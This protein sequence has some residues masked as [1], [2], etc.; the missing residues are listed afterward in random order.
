[1][2]EDES[3]AS[4]AERSGIEE[5]NEGGPLPSTDLADPE[6]AANSQLSIRNI[7]YWTI[8]DPGHTF[9]YYVG[10]IGN[11]HD[12]SMYVYVGNTTVPEWLLENVWTPSWEWKTS[13]LTNTSRTGTVRLFHMLRYNNQDSDWHDFNCVISPRPIIDTQL[14]YTNA[15]TGSGGDSTSV[16]VWVHEGSQISPEVTPTNSRWSLPLYSSVHPGTYLITVMQHV[17]GY[18]QRYALGKTITYLTYPKILVPRNG[19][20]IRLSAELKVS[21]DFGAP[22]RKI[23][24]ANASKDRE[25]G[26]GDADDSGRWEI[27][28][29]AASHFSVGGSITLN[30]RHIESIDAAWTTLSID[31][32]APP[33]IDTT[34]LEVEMNARIEGTG[35]TGFSGHHV[36]LYFQG[37]TERITGNWV[38]EGR[39]SIDV[40]LLP[41]KHTLTAEQVHKGVTSL[42]APLRV[43]HVRPA[44]P[45]PLQSRREGDFIFLHGTG[46][47]GPNVKIHINLYYIDANYLSASVTNGK[48]DIAI[49][50]TLAPKTYA[51]SCRQSVDGGENTRIYS[52]GWTSLVEINVPTPKPTVDTPAV[53][54]QGVTFS[55]LGR[56]WVNAKVQ[57]V[58]FE[59]DGTTEGNVIVKIDVPSTLAW[60][61][62]VSLAPGTYSN[63]KARQWVNSQFSDPA[64]IPQVIVPSQVPGLE[65]PGIG[66]IV[67]QTPQLKGITYKGSVVTFSIPGVEP[68]TAT[69]S[70]EG[71][72][73]ITAKELPPGIHTM[74]VTAEFGGQTSPALTRTFTVKTPVPEIITSDGDKLDPVPI[75]KGRG[76]KGGWL[77]IRSAEN[78][79]DLGK[80]PVG[81]G[82]DWSVQLAAQP[83]GE[84]KIYAL[85]FEKENSP[86]VSDPTEVVTVD[87]QLKPPTILQ[88]APNGKAE[89]VSEFSGEA[90]FRSTVELYIK[91]QLQPFVKDI[92]VG[93]NNT[94]NHIVTLPA[95]H[96]DLEVAVRYDGTLSA[97]ADH[98]VSVVPAVPKND[99]PLRAEK[100][101]TP[102]TMSGFGDKEG[103]E[104]VIESRDSADILGSTTV[105]D[106]KTWS[107]TV[108]QTMATDLRVAV[109]ARAGAG[110]DSAYTGTVQFTMLTPGPKIVEPQPGDWTGVRP[111]YS[112]LAEPGATIT[113]ALWFNS[114]T[115]LAEPTVAD[116]NGRWSVWGNQDLVEGAVWVVMRQTLDGRLSEWVESGRFMV[117][118]MP[119]GFEAPTVTFPLHG[120]EV[121][122]WPMFKGTGV[123]GSEVTIFKKGDS[124]TA[125]GS[126]KV[127]RNGEWEVRSQIELPVADNYECSV[128]QTRDG[129]T[130]AWLIPDRKFDVIQVPDGFGAAIIQAP[131]NDSSESHEQQPEFSGTGLAGAEVVIR[132]YNKTD[133]LAKTLVD[134]QGKWRVR[135]EVV[136]TVGPHEIVADQYR[137]GQC[138]TLSNTVTF[139]VAEKLYVPIIV[140]PNDN[141]HIT[142][143]G[144]IEGRALPGTVVR[145]V[146]ASHVSVA[147]GTG[148]TDAQ[149]RW[150]IV[151]KGL[152]VRK[153]SLIGDGKKNELKAH[154]ILARVFRVIDVG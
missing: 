121:G 147:Y 28:F 86:N 101:G 4:E 73:D 138:S 35:H 131:Q 37:A 105:L 45:G 107:T 106:D 103:D 118:R 41:G 82:G 61:K 87:I 29:D 6:V 34:P 84:L 19:D 102:F 69:A 42:R 153:I 44:M 50:A 65:K 146:D 85:M 78:H 1:M 88:P 97:K 43:V 33:I 54:T 142:P 152:P 114:D 3:K 112:G 27:K 74:T 79:G 144:V 100:V 96:T 52:N 60:T 72:F 94:W 130:S 99:T 119:A 10:V 116:E 133:V 47:V 135:S 139:T 109:M 11:Y 145:L 110:L 123:P 113:V 98:R 134:A 76:Y 70:A 62:L 140:S 53:S 58:I 63:L 38:K 128:R 129:V 13:K 59:G 49:P 48:W 117:E 77:V 56:H 71:I 30:V 26:T 122:R 91:G 66:A 143:D 127:H 120:Q 64:P 51:F 154:W 75:I 108:K 5:C 31:L 81:S 83:L 150:L 18:T 21:G 136:M 8:V 104:I 16:S 55:G 15:I 68:F 137:D 2:S 46:Y 14:V 17:P 132:L 32:L 9:Q 125:L 95:G 141:A 40:Q 124:N 22:R 67:G 149:G 93:S 89:R 20:V 7:D 151:L 25:L 57:V 12:V 39:W 80:G 23:Q 148:V 111:L 92:V 36:D 24:L 115:L 126:A 90:L